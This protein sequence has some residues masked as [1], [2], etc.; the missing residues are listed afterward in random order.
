M[1]LWMVIAGL[2][3]VLAVCT[4]MVWNPSRFHGLHRLYGFKLGEMTVR[5][6]AIRLNLL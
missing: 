4:N 3:M 5:M 1:Y 2:I 6:V